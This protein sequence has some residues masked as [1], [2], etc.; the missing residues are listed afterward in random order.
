ML[1]ESLRALIDQ[2]GGQQVVAERARYSQGH[3][4]KVLRG[5]AGLNRPKLER[6]L[7]ACG[8]SADDR[9]TLVRLHQAETSDHLEPPATMDEINHLVVELS[10]ASAEIDALVDENRTLIDLVG[11][12]GVDIEAAVDAVHQM[13]D[14]QAQAVSRLT[15]EASD[16]HDRMAKRIAELLATCLR[17]AWGIERLHRG[18]HQ[19]MPKADELD[20][21]ATWLHSTQVPPQ[22]PASLTQAITL[23]RSN[24]ER[25]RTWRTPPP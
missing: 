1:L 24:S 25:L 2:A 3:I 15:T 5:Q 10:S 14:E 21:I 7:N 17:L 23:L 11:R 13:G 16:H 8:A 18:D 4:S 20:A 6:I 22:L 12:A 9:A 19:L